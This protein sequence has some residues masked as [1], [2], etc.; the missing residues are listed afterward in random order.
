MRSLLDLL[1]TLPTYQ[2][3]TTLDPATVPIAQITLDSRTVAPG[4]L[5]VALQG[6][7]ADGHRYI[8]DTIKRGAAAVIGALPPAE[9]EKQ[10]IHLPANSAYIQAPDTRLALAFCAAALYDF[11]SR[12]MTV[13]G[14]TGTDGKTTTSSLIEAI[15][16]AHTRSSAE[17]NGRVGVITTV[18][19][20]IRGQ[21]NDTGLHVTTP[22]A[23]EVQHFLAQM[24][25]AGCTYAVVEST[26]HGLDQ[27]RVAAV[28][29]DIAVVTNITHE[30]L[31]Y[32]GTR[33]AYVAAKA[34][35][36]RA[37]FAS[38]AKLDTPR[39]AVWNADDVGSFGALQ[40]VL[41]EETAQ[42]GPVVA[43]RTYGIASTPSAPKADVTVA[44][45]AYFP[46]RTAF[47]VHWWGGVFPLETPLIGDFNV[48]NV[49]AAVTVALALG[50][51]PATIQAGVRNFPGVLG[52]MQRMDQ[53]QP[54]LALVDFAHT[55]VSLE[56]ALLTLRPLVGNQQTNGKG[57][58]IAV[59]GSAGLRDRAK[60]RLMGQV[61][62]RL[63]DF[64]VITAEDP[65][66][67]DLNEINAEIASG[68]REFAPEERFVI[69]P[70]RTQAIQFAIDLAEPGDVVAA[71]GK[72]HERSMCFGTTEYPWSDQQAMLEALQ[73]RKGLRIR[74]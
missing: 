40:A 1:Q 5:F 8:P 34:K 54:F 15:L 17:E 29:F 10:G 44:E 48:S 21:E 46:D 47:T 14:V 51:A 60:R 69:V 30:H 55:P 71:F 23:P 59:F 35:L 3:Y 41:A 32:H 53:G 39:C 12:S 38:P 26:S 25:E 49:L 31:D 68:V 64:T 43:V 65:R 66:T 56:R 74:N 72:G 62:G 28:D 20:R 18:G 45:V 61:S 70:D 4:A 42:H 52:R 33:D 13:I 63:A 9:L 7:Q 50:V 2:L 58:L 37:L 57:R 67:E 16:A 24:R 22:E 19:A 27:A 6:R 73:K 36:F 11:P